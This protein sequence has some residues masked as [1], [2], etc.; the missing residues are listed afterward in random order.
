M[1]CSE[2]DNKPTMKKVAETIPYTIAGI[3]FQLKGL[4]VPTCPECGNKEIVIPAIKN[5]HMVVAEI[6]VSQV[7]DL[8]GPQIKFLR[9]FMRLNQQQFHS[10]VSDNPSD[11]VVSRWEND[12]TSPG[13]PT[14]LLIKKLVQEKIQEDQK[15]FERIADQIQKA[16]TAAKLDEFLA[17]LS[18]KEFLKGQ[19][20]CRNREALSN[21]LT[22]TGSAYVQVRAG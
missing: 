5:L 4:K 19:Q 22:Y 14:L 10:L 1:K 6:L 2:C 7:S 20:E 13:Y 15:E 16:E 3:E 8:K 21:F 9:K 17:P 12:K 18:L 11:A